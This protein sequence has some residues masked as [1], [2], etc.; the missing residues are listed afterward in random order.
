MEHPNEN[1]FHYLRWRGDLT[2]AAD[3]LNEADA[4]AFATF[5]YLD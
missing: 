1:L 2:F 5:S 3:P 4:L